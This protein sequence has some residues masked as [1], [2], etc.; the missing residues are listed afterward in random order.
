MQ[1][2]CILV[3]RV[4]SK[5]GRA[6]GEATSDACSG[7]SAV[8]PETSGPVDSWGWMGDS[9]GWDVASFLWGGGGAED[10]EGV[11]SPPEACRDLP[12]PSQHH[13]FHFLSPGLLSPSPMQQLLTYRPPLSWH[14][15]FK[16]TPIPENK[17]Q[18]K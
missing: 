9:G 16:A 3:G 8:G 5:A 10:M 1:R 12:S 2:G 6:T 13:C 17:V 15:P 7:M 18:Q 4:S 14:S 11:T